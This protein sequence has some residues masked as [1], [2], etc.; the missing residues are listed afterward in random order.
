MSRLFLF[1]RK[2]RGVLVETRVAVVLRHIQRETAMPQRD[3][4]RYYKASGGPLAYPQTDLNH[5]NRF[6]SVRRGVGAEVGEEMLDGG[7]DALI[8]VRNV[9]LFICPLRHEHDEWM[10]EQKTVRTWI[11]RGPTADEWAVLLTPDEWTEAYEFWERKLT[12][13]QS[14]TLEGQLEP[15][16]WIRRLENVARDGRHART[17]SEQKRDALVEEVRRQMIADGEL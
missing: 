11:W 15:E 1:G 6:T 4:T 13:N 8:Q 9:K 7:P 16:E 10:C 2:E 12:N 17:L 3:V 5:F 14:H